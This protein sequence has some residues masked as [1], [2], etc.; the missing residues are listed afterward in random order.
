[1]EE[2]LME[3]MYE[4]PDEK[5]ISEIVIDEKVITEGA[6]PKLVKHQAEEK[7]SA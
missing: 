1:M 3:W 6:K 2:I 7:K 5:D 4:L